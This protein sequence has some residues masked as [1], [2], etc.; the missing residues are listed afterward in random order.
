MAGDGLVLAAL[1]ALPALALALDGRWG[2]TRWS[3]RPLGVV[4]VLASDPCAGELVVVAGGGM[5]AVALALAR[6]ANMVAL[7]RFRL[8]VAVA[9]AVRARLLAPGR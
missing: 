1:L 6:A 3:P 5:V 2:D 8:L 9:D 7:E 4:V